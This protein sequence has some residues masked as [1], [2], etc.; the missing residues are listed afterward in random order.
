MKLKIL[1][2]KK[3]TFILLA[4]ISGTA[5]AQNSG[6]ATAVVN[7]EI[8][9]PIT[10]SSTGVLDFGKITPN[11]SV[12]QV[13]LTPANVRTLSAG[14]IVPGS[15]T[16]TVPTFTVVKETG[17]AY[18]VVTGSTD[19]ALSGAPAIKLKD[20]TTSLDGSGSYT[21]SEFTVG[22]TLEIAGD[23]PAGVYEGQVSITVSYE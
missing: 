13:R 9:K 3:I 20:I 5:F 2:M 23:Q 17:L 1:K 10:I 19:L 12:G 14:M 15:T 16:T 4:L 8:V 7:A 22:G 6:S 11:G 18:T 21:A